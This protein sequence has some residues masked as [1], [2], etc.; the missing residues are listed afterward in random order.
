[1][2]DVTSDQPIT[3]MN[4]LY[5]PPTCE[6][7]RFYASAGKMLYTP[8]VEEKKPSEF[9]SSFFQT[10]GRSMNARYFLKEDIYGVIFNA[11]WV[12]CAF[13]SGGRHERLFYNVTGIYDAMRAEYRAQVKLEST[14][15][16]NGEDVLTTSSPKHQA[17]KRPTI[18][19]A[20]SMLEDQE[21]DVDDDD[22]LLVYST[23][24]DQSKVSHD[25]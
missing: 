8:R 13:L 18:P 12:S 6:V 11:Q 9:P 5:I 1:M 14:K 19:P 10:N 15:C 7:K 3:S 24:G 21:D 16:Q 23:V 4:I 2:A 25:H 17:K 20:I 22:E